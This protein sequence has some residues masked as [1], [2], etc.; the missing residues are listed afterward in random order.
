MRLGGGAG[1]GISRD[2]SKGIRKD[3]IIRWQWVR[4][5]GNHMGK[6]RGRGCS[7]R[8]TRFSVEMEMGGMEGLE[9]EDR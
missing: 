3:I 2:I 5:P 8:R 6:G 9:L 7:M 4:C 1:L